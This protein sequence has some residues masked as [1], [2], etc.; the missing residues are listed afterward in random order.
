VWR[1]GS[2]PALGERSGEEEDDEDH[3]F[4]DAGRSSGGLTGSG[5]GSADGGCG[6]P[7]GGYLSGQERQDS[8]LRLLLRQTHATGV[9]EG[10]SEYSHEERQDPQL[11]EQDLNLFHALDLFE[12][13]N[14]Q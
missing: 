11:D 1:R 3:P 7:C 12:V 10:T 13:G 9:V 2:T 14:E 8:L 4:G 6:A 5:V